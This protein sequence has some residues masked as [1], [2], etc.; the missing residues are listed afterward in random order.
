MVFPEFLTSD[1][2]KIQGH[3]CYHNTTCSVGKEVQSEI[4]GGCCYKLFAFTSYNMI[5][6]LIAIYVTQT[7]V[8]KDFDK[9]GNIR[10]FSF[11][12]DKLV[13]WITAMVL[14]VSKIYTQT[15][16]FIF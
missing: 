6:I 12:T 7:L 13:I 3:S 16:D 5:W 2:V 11:I 9:H 10:K 15:G 4:T 8:Y 14:V 1:D